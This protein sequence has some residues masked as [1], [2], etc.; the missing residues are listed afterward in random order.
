MSRWQPTWQCPGD[1]LS[2]ILAVPAKLALEIDESFLSTHTLC[3]FP[4]RCSRYILLK[5][6][7]TNERDGVLDIFFLFPHWCSRYCHCSHFVYGCTCA[8]SVHHRPRLLCLVLFPSESARGPRHLARFRFHWRALIASWNWCP[9]DATLR[10][11]LCAPAVGVFHL[12]WALLYPV[13]WVCHRCLR[14]GWASAGNV[15]NPLLGLINA[16][17]P[18]LVFF[19]QTNSF[20]I[21]LLSK[22]AEIY[23]IMAKTLLI[24]FPPS[25]G[26]PFAIIKYC[27]FM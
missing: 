27:I 16:P 2:G 14:S 10:A 6:S 13:T 25:W 1:L 21:D 9:L 3:I 24:T 4:P 7:R 5:R 22:R 19:L 17:P 20:T 15:Y 26:D 12:D 18:L 23:K 11:S 8:H